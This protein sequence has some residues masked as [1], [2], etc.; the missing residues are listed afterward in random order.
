M[1]ATAW[2]EALLDTMG[3]AAVLVRADGS[4]ER[5]NAVAGATF[6]SPSATLRDRPLV[7][8]LPELTA[9]MLVR[10]A[11]ESGGPRRRHGTRAHTAEGLTTVPAS[12][13]RVDGDSE[14]PPRYVVV[15]GDVD[16]E[17]RTERAF[18]AVVEATSS[19]TGTALF[20]ALTRSLAEA[21]GMRHALVAEVAEGNRARSLS[22]W[23][24]ETH[25]APVEYALDGTPCAEVAERGQCQF[26][27]DLRT[28]FPD[29]QVL[30]EMGAESYIGEPILDDEGRPIGLV[31]LLD[32]APL[33]DPDLPGSL[34]AMAAA[35]A[36]AELLRLRSETALRDR[37]AELRALTDNMP[38]VVFR[39][40]RNYHYRYINPAT[41]AFIGR[42]RD[43][44][45]GRHPADIVSPEVYATS[46]RVLARVLAG[47]SV[48]IER[49]FP[50]PDGTRWLDV[51]YFPERDASGAVQGVCGIGIDITA[52]KQTELALR[53][54]E[55]RTRAFAEIGSDWFWETDAEHRFAYVSSRTLDAIGFDIHKVL[56]HSRVELLR[57]LMTEEEWRAHVA[58]LDARRP[59]RSMKVRRLFPDG[60][61][62]H[63]SISGSPVHDAEGRFTGYRGTGSNIT[64]EVRLRARAESA[65]AQLR[66][67]IECLE[68]AFVLYDRDDR[69]VI[70]NERYRQTYPRSAPA[71]RP[72]AR[73]EDIVRYGLERGEY[74]DAVGRET[75]WLAERMAQHQRATNVIEQRTGDGRW[76]R[77]AEQRTPDG[78]VVGFR[79]DITELKQAY[80]RV[81]ASHRM[82]ERTV[83]SMPQG[84]LVLDAER[85]VVAY[86]DAFADMLGYPR[87]QFVPGTGFDDLLRYQAARGGLGPE[88]P[89]ALLAA[90]LDATPRLA[91]FRFEFSRE[92]RFVEAFATPVP[93]AGLVTVFTDVTEHKTMQRTLVD[94]RDQAESVARAKSEFL[95]TMSHEI[96]TPMNGVLGLAELLLQT[97]LD[98]EQ[99]EYAETLHRS[100]QSLLTIVNDILDFSK[101]EAGQLEIESVEFDLPALAEDVVA[102]WAPAAHER[103][104][105]LILHLVDGLARTVVGDPGR[106]RQV[107]ENLVGNAVKFTERGH[108][109]VRIGAGTDGLRF[110]VQDTG[111]G[112]SPQARAHLFQAFAQA[113]ASTT[114]RFGGTGLGLAICRRL[115]ALMD[116]EIGVESTPGEGS[117]FWFHLP[118]ASGAPAPEAPPLRAEVLLVDE[119][120]LSRDA[121][122]AQLRGLGLTVHSAAGLAEAARWL[123]CERA[124]AAMV[125][126]VRPGGIQPRAVA[127]ML[128]GSSAAPRAALLLL[129]DSPSGCHGARVPG[130]GACVTRPAR[131]ATLRAALEAAIGRQG[132]AAAAARPV[133][134]WLRGRVLVVEDNAVNRHVARAT[135][136]KLGLTVSEATN[137]REAVEAVARERPDL[138]LMDMH[139]PVMDGLDA[140]RAI[141]AA[142]DP[143]SP[144]LPIVALTANV[145]TEATDDCLTAGMDA[146]ITKPLGRERLL[147]TLGR[148]LGATSPETTEPSPVRSAGRA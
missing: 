76:L 96:R 140:T 144:R 88:Q 46:E 52:R 17:R 112:I 81:E 66:D 23:N 101:V 34:L 42:P 114:R 105:E 141:R 8:V 26:L 131:T 136:R 127:A 38:A 108:V 43:E 35:R 41:E 57:A 135:L 82:L 90:R 100:G 93:G 6:A 27:S 50:Q 75:Q 74:A 117:T 69:L 3:E 31:A 111:V 104:I 97:D 138:V 61:E 91:P 4:I 1:G 128:G 113:D 107:L 78:G 146:F 29:D 18:R 39:L 92:R 19:A 106:V 89:E 56:G 44:V 125:A 145:T 132:P 45:V 103:E 25:G 58:D 130:A 20:D 40:G 121:L 48:A 5:A 7:E 63:F 33:H 116:G 129:S 62:E 77:I 36:G 115:V 2:L 28:A 51:T 68:E 99:R 84:V 80:E 32:V 95:A 123:Q 102:R 124:P 142:E 64:E 59:F 65:E 122:A 21:T 139:M 47:E 148:W 12:V 30:V 22:F 110:E 10:M 118:L 37:E 120:P 83:L 79:F 98:N 70:C 13:H 87:D 16:R 126:S 54:A 71:I 143:A 60:R 109:L 67:A 119:H 137:G 11:T 134:P 85:R 24:G 53:K 147:A 133:G 55:E 9:D 86:N 15:I 49:D 14:Q 94:A 72:G 73:F